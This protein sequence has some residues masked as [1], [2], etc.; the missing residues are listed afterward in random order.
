M[1]V[2]ISAAIHVALKAIGPAAPLW[3]LI[4]SSL[5]VGS[6]VGVAVGRA[7]SAIAESVVNK[8]R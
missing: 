1:G 8:R 3:L 6:V 2:F 5:V 7:A 4:T